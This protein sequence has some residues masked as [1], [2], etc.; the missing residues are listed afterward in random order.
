MPQ[1]ARGGRGSLGQDKHTPRPCIF[2]RSNTL[3]RT[4]HSWLGRSARSR[5]RRRTQS[6]RWGTGHRRRPDRSPPLRTPSRTPRSRSGRSVRRRM[7]NRKETG[8]SG[9]RS[10]QRDRARHPGTRPRTRHNCLGQSARRRSTRCN[11]SPRRFDTHPLDPRSSIDTKSWGM[12]GRRWWR[13][14]S[15]FPPNRS[16]RGPC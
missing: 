5:K 15:R 8:P 12:D 3:R 4:S 6:H 10:S 2:F 11:W 1:R 7:R 16:R 14:R 9:R 13:C